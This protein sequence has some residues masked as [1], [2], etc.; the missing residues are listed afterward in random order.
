[1]NHQINDFA[2]CSV[3]DLEAGSLPPPSFAGNLPSNVNK[4]QYLSPKLQC[5]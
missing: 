5:I 2:M 4:A 3:A 1:M